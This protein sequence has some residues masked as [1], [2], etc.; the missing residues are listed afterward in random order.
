MRTQ[1]MEYLKSLKDFPRHKQ[2]SSKANESIP[3]QTNG[4][5]CG[6]FMLMFLKYKSIDKSYNFTQDDMDS[7]RKIIKEELQMQSLK[8]PEIE[9]IIED[10]EVNEEEQVEHNIHS[11][12]PP[13]FSNTCSTLCW[14]NSMLQFLIEIIEFTETESYLKS[15]LINFK[16]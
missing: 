14:L 15:M 2:Y 6:V 9:E 13:Q 11:L 7:F 16:H 3:D 1:I 12:K 5:D 4:H 8:I 10:M